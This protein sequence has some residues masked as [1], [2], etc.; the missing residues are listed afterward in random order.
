MELTEKA[1]QVR[2]VLTN[3]QGISEQTNLLALNAS[4]E[5]ARAGQQGRAF[6]VVADEVRALASKT[7]GLTGT[8]ETILDSFQSS[9]ELAVD[10]MNRS[11]N[12]VTEGVV[13]VDSSNIRLTHI[14]Q[15]V[16]EIQQ[17]NFRVLAAAKQQSIA[18]KDISSGVF[19][20]NMVASEVVEEAESIRSNS[21]SLTKLSE[22]LSMQVRQFKC[23]NE[24]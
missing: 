15:T 8:I 20:V 19:N 23:N 10:A 1:N 5:A 2:S 16:A 17:L 18:S 6:A 4:I 22:S 13:L 14:L 7:Q 24:K 21:A 3:I 12:I 9:S 11:Q